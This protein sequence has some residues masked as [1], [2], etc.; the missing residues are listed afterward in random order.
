MTD[1]FLELKKVT[2]SIYPLNDASFEGFAQIF[3][4]FE[5]KRKVILTHE[6]SIE[7]IPWVKT[8]EMSHWFS[9]ILIHFQ[10]WRIHF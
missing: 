6:G 2:Q 5:A 7:L 8:G 3:Q 10:V 9:L 1:T 4:P